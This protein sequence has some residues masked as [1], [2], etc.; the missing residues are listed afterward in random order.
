MLLPS[1]FNAIIIVGVLVL[2]TL[3]GG[4]PAADTTIQNRGAIGRL[5]LYLLCDLC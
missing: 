3:C 4:I 1:P 5:Y 2:N